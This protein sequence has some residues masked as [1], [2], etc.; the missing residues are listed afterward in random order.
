V[1]RHLD[2]HLLAATD[3][4][5]IDVLEDTANRVALHVFGKREPRLAFNVQAQ[6]DIGG[7]DRAHQIVAGK[8]DMQRRL[9]VP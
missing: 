5:Q 4:Q 3:K 2:R 6:E 1:N 8:R 9:A 7:P